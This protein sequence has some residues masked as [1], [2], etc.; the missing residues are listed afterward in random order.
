MD[1]ESQDKDKRL[2]E[3]KRRLED[4]ERRIG[5]FMPKVVSK[6]GVRRGEWRSDYPL[7]TGDLPKHR[8]KVTA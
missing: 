8:R 2:E 6:E 3:G 1:K 5:R 7:V 4:I